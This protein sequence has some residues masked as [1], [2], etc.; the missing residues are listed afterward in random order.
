VPRWTKQDAGHVGG[1]GGNGKNC[2]RQSRRWN[3]SGKLYGEESQALR[4]SQW[5]QTDGG[6]SPPQRRQEERKRRTLSCANRA[7]RRLAD[8]LFRCSGWKTS[9]KSKFHQRELSEAYFNE[10]WRSTTTIKWSV[11]QEQRR[12]QPRTVYWVDRGLK[13]YPGPRG[14]CPIPCHTML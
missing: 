2:P 10:E 4:I 3:L 7:A 9:Q 5:A 14:R 1:E 6:V 13:T 8:G 11:C 12:D